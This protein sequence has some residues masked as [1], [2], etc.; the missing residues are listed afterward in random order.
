MTYMQR[1]ESGTNHQQKPQILLSSA[2][3]NALYSLQVD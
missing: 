2:A 1:D 3:T